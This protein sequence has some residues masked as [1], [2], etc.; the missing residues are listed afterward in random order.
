MKVF[1][2]HVRRKINDRQTSLLPHLRAFTTS[3]N[4]HLPKIRFHLYLL[5]PWKKRY[6]TSSPRAMT[7]MMRK[8]SPLCLRLHHQ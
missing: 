8:R 3:P 1:F 6:L 4:H 2:P 7:A 5:S